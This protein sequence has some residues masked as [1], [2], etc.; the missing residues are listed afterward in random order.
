MTRAFLYDDSVSIKLNPIP[1][2]LGPTASN[3]TAVGIE[4]AKL[5]NGEVISVDSRKVYKGLPIGT[6]TP[7]GSWQTSVYVV[8]GISHHL[9]AFL[10]PDLF[11]TAGDFVRDADNLIRLIQKIGKTPILVGGTGFYFKALYEGLPPLPAR[12]SHIR[13]YLEDLISKKGLSYLHE[14]L[15]KVDPAAAQKISVQDRHKLIRAMEIFHITKK[16]YSE[17]KNQNKVVSPFSFNIMALEFPKPE[18]ED[19]IEKRSKRMVEHGM[20][21]EAKKLL[22]E[23]YSKTCP[24]LASFG[25]KEAVQVIEGILPE[26]EFLPHLIKQTKAYAKR[27]R[28]WFRTQVKPLWFP[29]AEGTNEEIALKMKD[30]L[31]H[32]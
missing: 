3:K 21:Q 1:V 26:T 2:I 25:Y 18:L 4:L 19:R 16:P 32:H 15:R 20:I 22:E 23:G 11:Y 7:P 27:Q 8:K 10:S 29:C 24:A 28:T 6:A 9:M 14:E 30:F 17:F 13:N 5:L 12:D 31:Y